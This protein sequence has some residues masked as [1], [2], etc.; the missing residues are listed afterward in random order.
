MLS[1]PPL[2]LSCAWEVPRPA[3]EESEIKNR[4]KRY[5]QVA[6]AVRRRDGGGEEGGTGE[7]KAYIGKGTPRQGSNVWSDGKIRQRVREERKKG[8]KEERKKGRKEGEGREEEDI[9]QPPQ[10]YNSA[11]VTLYFH[12][13][14]QSL[15]KPHQPKCAPI[16]QHQC[17]A[18]PRSRDT[19][20]R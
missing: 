1:P 11:T 16:L 20:T 6:A 4:I 15:S 12:D 17:T 3:V 18:P 19:T 9:L 8:R 2:R 13:T 7:A 10:K 5:R 14:A